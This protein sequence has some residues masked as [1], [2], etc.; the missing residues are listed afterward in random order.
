MNTKTSLVRYNSFATVEFWQKVCQLKLKDLKLKREMPISSYVDKNGLMRFDEQSFGS[1]SSSTTTICYHGKLVVFNSLHEMKEYVNP[2]Q[3]GCDPKGISK[4]PPFENTVKTYLHEQLKTGNVRC[5]LLLVYCDL[6]TFKIHHWLVT[7]AV[8]PPKFHERLYLPGLDK[9]NIGRM[10]ETKGIGAVSI[11]AIRKDVNTSVHEIGSFLFSSGVTEGT[12][13]S[14]GIKGTSG[15]EGYAG[16]EGTSGTTVDVLEYNPFDISTTYNMSIKRFDVSEIDPNKI[17]KGFEL[18]ENGKLA[19]RVTDL[20]AFMDPETLAARNADLNVQLIKWRHMPD[21]DFE[22]IQ[23]TKFLLLGAGTLGCNVARALMGWGARK[24]TLVDNGKVSYSNPAR[25]SLF[26]YRDSAERRNKAERAAEVLGE[27]LP[28]MEARGVVLDIPMLGHGA[29][30]SGADDTAELD[31]LIEGHDIVIML[32]DSRESRWL[33]TVLSLARG[34]QVFNAALGFD[35]YVVMRHPSSSLSADDDQNSRCY[36][37]SNTSAPRDSL[38]R[39]SLDQQC[40]VTRPGLSLIASGICAEMV[41]DHINGKRTSNV[42][43]GF[44]SSSD[45]TQQVEKGQQRSKHCVACSPEIVKAINPPG[46][47]IIEYE[48]IDCILKDPSI[49][50]RISGLD[51]EQQEIQDKLK[52]LDFAF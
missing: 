13:E 28:S 36:F 30:T 14:A 17:I 52:N 12:K 39:R 21:L 19:P 18:N 16:I 25:Q 22:K 45:M 5:F 6:K 15:I 38:T 3:K 43:R 31:T 24:I 8:S 40:T 23:S 49:L 32:T 10:L 27:I 47:V 29:K 35:H 11:C 46:R 26:T 42:V 7:P 4:P 41:V 2:P 37:C 34:R 51:A 50:E 9:D 44:V 33:P 48:L 20:S 1:E